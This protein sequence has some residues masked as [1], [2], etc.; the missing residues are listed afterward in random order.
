[1]A[2]ADIVEKL[3][4]EVERLI[5]DHRR[6]AAECRELIKERD[7]L[8]RDKRRLEEK[9]RELDTRLRSSELSDVMRGTGGDV[10]RA[11]KRVNNLLREVDRC[12]AA[13]KYKEEKQE[14]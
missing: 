2:H 11:R 9:V 5:A 3:R 13:L 4:K 8:Q 12:I 1:M 14:E 6:I 10:D 7:T